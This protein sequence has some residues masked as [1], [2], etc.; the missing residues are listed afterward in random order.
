MDARLSKPLE[1]KIPRLI[2]H[3]KLKSWR[4]APLDT[5]EE[6]QYCVRE[7]IFQKGRVAMSRIIVPEKES[8]AYVSKLFQTIGAE[9]KHADVVADHLTM[10]EMR[11]QASHGLNRIPFYTQKLEHGGYKANPHM[12][13]L[14][15]DAGVAL[16][17]ADDAL[18]AVSCSHAMELCMEKASRTG[19][20]SVAVTHSNHI[21]F[22]AY[23][24]MMAAKRNMI[25]IAVCN[26]GSSTAVW[27]TRERVLGTDPFSI[28]VPAKKHF[29]VILDCA[30]SVVAQGKVSVA[31]TENK[32]IPGNWAYNKNGEPTTVA[33]EAMV[34]T[35]RPFGDYKGSGIAIVI[36]LICAGLTGM[37]FDFEEENLRR[38][39][40]L[41][42]GSELAASLI[43]I[44]ISKFTDAEAFKH[45][46]D[47]FI[48]V[49]KSFK[50]APD[51]EQIYMPGEIEFN[52]VAANR[53]AGG[54]EIGPNLYQKLKNIRDQYGMK[55]EMDHWKHDD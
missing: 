49:V 15:E 43:A 4:Y 48:D 53:A 40:D 24:T 29:P 21:G 18:G 23:Y 51:T 8:Q 54:F 36:S 26:S 25:G 42:A 10:A 27:G 31:E 13:I 6:V 44:D 38:I 28:G 11:G 7:N 9:K 1:L 14:R 3:E 39:S 32:P 16:L 17:D 12:K 5:F 52:K 45:R 47:G 2:Y 37:P 22:L 20:A 55:F 19:C 30:T 41:S 50:L 46:V 35:M 34:G 33:S